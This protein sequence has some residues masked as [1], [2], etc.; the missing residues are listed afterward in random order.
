MVHILSTKIRLFSFSTTLSERVSCLPM[1]LLQGR[2]QDVLK[3]GPPSRQSRWVRTDFRVHTCR[4]NLVPAAGCQPCFK[5][6]F[7]DLYACNYLSSN[8]HTWNAAFL[9]KGD[10]ISSFKHW[11]TAVTILWKCALKV[12]RRK[13]VSSPSWNTAQKQR[14]GDLS[15]W[16]V[17]SWVAPVHVI[18]EYNGW[19][20]FLL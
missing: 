15:E 17:G 13:V 9:E 20:L 16:R 6:R 10:L 1:A 14:Q 3:T 7:V 11:W 2:V 5:N 8:S 12:G 18:N 4:L 19:Q